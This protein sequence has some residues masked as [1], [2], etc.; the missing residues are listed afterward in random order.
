MATFV[1]RLF[2]WLRQHPRSGWVFLLLYAPIVTFPH[3]QVQTVVGELAKWTGRANLYRLAAGL[4][5]AIVAALTLALLPAMRRHAFRGLIAAYWAATL[6]LIVATWAM[7]TANNTE[8]VHYPQY[9]VPGV[10]LMVLT[11]SPLESLAWIAITG[12]LDECFQYWGMH[13]GW[14]IPFDFND[15]FM[16][17]LGG[18]LGV[19]FALA[20]LR[21][22]GSTRPAFG[23]F[24]RRTF[25]KPGAALVLAILLSAPV[26][27]ATGK[28][29]L[30]EDKQNTS[31]WF[32]LSRLPS[33]PFWFF[34]ETWGPKTFHTLSPLEGPVLLIAAL[35]LY[36][37]LDRKLTISYPDERQ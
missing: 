26:L 23:P 35:A 8:L 9:F 33:Q 27:Y 15:I 32:A 20:F 28:M 17:L 6:L 14:G 11:L 31:Y 1:S 36:G 25:S 30:Y 19:V 3:E 21:C 18:A 24:L 4:G 22:D 29:L 5:I 7:L 12:G 37:L 16:D 10:V 2:L 13:A 34:D